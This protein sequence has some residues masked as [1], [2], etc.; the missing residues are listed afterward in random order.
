METLIKFVVLGIVILF[1]FVVMAVLRHT[2][3]HAEQAEPKRKGGVPE[4]VENFPKKY[5]RRTREAIKSL[6]ISEPMLGLVAVVILIA[7]TGL[8]RHFPGPIDPHVA[9][10]WMWIKNWWVTLAEA[11]LIS[12]AIGYL[13][14]YWTSSKKA[15]GIAALLLVTYMLWTTL[16]VPVSHVQ[17][18]LTPSRQASNDVSAPP[19]YNPPPAAETPPQ[20][21]AK[22]LP[23]NDDAY[24]CTKSLSFNAQDETEK[25]P[26]SANG[27][28][29]CFTPE[30]RWTGQVE[31]HLW[32]N[33]VDLGS[34]PL[35]EKDDQGKQRATAL[36]DYD[37]VAYVR[38]DSTLDHVDV[39]KA[40]GGASCQKQ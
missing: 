30:L 28:F 18:V 9:N 17:E 26:K 32:K 27:D 40:P 15:A 10:V 22:E 29:D 23:C 39:W 8:W 5:F 12:A 2:K 7:T 14:S 37:Q 25:Q 24:Y 3:K 13:L 21:I 38:K 1:G 11:A 34:F 35:S 33:N 4:P 20:Q 31:E 36:P 19:T 6:G 16:S